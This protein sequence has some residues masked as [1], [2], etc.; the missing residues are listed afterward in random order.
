M[1]QQYSTKVSDRI[2]TITASL[3]LG[4]ILILQINNQFMNIRNMGAY[5]Q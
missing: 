3:L 4:Y 5:Q 1:Q 2:L